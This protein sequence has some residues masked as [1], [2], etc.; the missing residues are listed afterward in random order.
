MG[1]PSNGKSKNAGLMFSPIE[2]S[3]L[4]V[5]TLNWQ[6]G[7]ELAEKTGQTCSSWFRAILSNLVEREWLE[8]GR[9]GYRRR[10]DLEYPNLA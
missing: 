1:L 2:K 10:A 5:A 9:N 8:G 3:V 4:K 7:M 6:T